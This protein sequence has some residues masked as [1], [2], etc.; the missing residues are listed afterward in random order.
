MTDLSQQTLQD[1]KVGAITSCQAT[2]LTNPVVRAKM[3][4]R[5]GAFADLGGLEVHASASGKRWS[6]KDFCCSPGMAITP[7]LTISPGQPVTNHLRGEL[8][9]GGDEDNTKTTNEFTL[10][11]YDS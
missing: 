5:A 8:N 9:F 3:S 2:W 1:S 11:K 4:G 6:T 10:N 7:N